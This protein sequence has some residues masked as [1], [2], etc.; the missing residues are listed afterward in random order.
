[1]SIDAFGSIGLELVI[2]AFFLAIVMELVDSSLGMMYGT[3]L[4]PILILLGFGAKLVVPSLVLSQAVGGAIAT[5]RHN[6]YKNAD[7]NGWTRDFKVVMAVVVPG[8]IAAGCGALVAF[9][10]PS[11]WLN[12]YIAI[13]VILMGALCIR[14]IYYNFKWWKIWAVGLV[15]GFNKAASGGGFGPVTST[16]K[17]LGGLSS[18]VSVATTTAAEVPICL[19]SFAI[20]YLLQHKL[21]WTL[22]LVLG[23][24]ALIGGFIGPYITFKIN[25]KWL[26]IIIGVIAVIC[27]GLLLALKMKI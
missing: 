11:G 26:R 27:G 20:W 6:G 23:I 19:V 12:L 14:P 21:D 7:L 25:T 1:M 16:G 2:V 18:K 4:S 8:V 5:F 22:P 3:L 24:G 15:S 10:I 13:I 17:I 9:T